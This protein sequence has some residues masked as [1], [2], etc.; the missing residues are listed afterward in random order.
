MRKK[1]VLLGFVETMYFVDEKNGACLQIPVLLGTL[2]DG[3]DIFLAGSDGGDFD[4]VGFELMCKDAGE[5]SLA[6]ARWS[7][8]DKIYR[9]AFFD[10]FGQ[11]LTIANNLVLAIDVFKLGR[12]HTLSER[13]PIHI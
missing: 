10:N 11:N 3:F 6:S 5:G 1:S 9:L 4:K 12:A 7:P 8:E 2:D 13:N